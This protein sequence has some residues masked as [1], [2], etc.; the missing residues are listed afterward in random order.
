MAAVKADNQATSIMPPM[1]S[2]SEGAAAERCERSQPVIGVCQ[3]P[4]ITWK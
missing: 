1:A 3:E 2:G 4:L